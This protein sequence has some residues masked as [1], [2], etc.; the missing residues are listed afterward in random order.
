M[1]CGWVE[2]WMVRETWHSDFKVTWEVQRG[3]IKETVI[4]LD[5]TRGRNPDEMV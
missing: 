3:A 1:C 4:E 5:S 2:G